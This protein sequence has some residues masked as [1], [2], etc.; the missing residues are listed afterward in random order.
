MPLKNSR[1]QAQRIF[2]VYR[3]R[4]ARVQFGEKGAFSG[5]QLG[6]IAGLVS[7]DKTFA[8]RLHSKRLDAQRFQ[9]LS[10]GAQQGGIT[11][12]FKHWD[13]FEDF[14]RRRW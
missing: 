2:F 11:Q 9:H 10:D 8:V 14:S 6:A 1:R 5:R 7:N 3:G 13:P 12:I 4:V